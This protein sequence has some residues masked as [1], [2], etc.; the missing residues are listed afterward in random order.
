M[1]E[2]IVE[3]EHITKR[4]SGVTALNDVSFRIRTGEIHILAGEN[5][6]GKST[7]LKILSGIYEPDGG[8]VLLRGKKVAFRSPTES[9]AAGIAMVFQELTQV[10]ELTIFEN[11]FLSKERKKHGFIDKKRQMEILQACMDKYGLK[12]KPSTIVDRLS[13]G[14]K[15]LAEI[16]K[17]LVREPDIIILDEP[18]SA[19]TT[20]EVDILFSIMRKLKDEGKAVVFISHRIEEM[21]QIGDV[22]TVFKD[23]ELVDTTPVQE[24]TSDELIA[25]MVGRTLHDIFPPKAV[26][27]GDPV[28]EIKDLRF[29]ALDTPISL[30]VRKGEIIGI[31]GLAGHGQTELL[32]ALSGLHHIQTATIMVRGKRVNVKT[33]AAAV[34]S[35][36]SLIPGDRKQEGLMLKQSIRNNIAISSLGSRK[37]LGVFIS[38]KAERRMVQSYRKKLSIKMVSAAQEAAELSGGNQQKVVLAKGLATNPCVMLFNEPTK[39]ID[40]GSKR[41]IYYIMRDLASKG[42]AVIMYSSDLMEVIGMSD[43]VLVMYENNVSAELTGDDIT[44]E[45]IMRCAMGLSKEKDGGKRVS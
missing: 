1:P 19:L 28:F 24:L 43:R 34:K 15:Q 21:F 3:M 7:L 42:V 40:V 36:I 37:R 6:A 44:E 9:Q 32:N 27:T 38:H 20:E 25:K 26:S 10:N 35:G 33:S 8:T 39:G 29:H 17:V 4:F 30:S 22:L 12:M 31:A 14:Q 5:G 2:C 23:G 16:L 11:I 45:T 13:V 18:T 41:E